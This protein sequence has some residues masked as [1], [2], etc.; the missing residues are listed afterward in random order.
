[1]KIEQFSRKI[2]RKIVRIIVHFPAKWY[3]NRQFKQAFTDDYDAFW[4]VDIDNTI[5]HTWP[6]MTPQYE[7]AFR[8]QS[9]KM[10]SFE[11]FEAMQQL[12]QDVPP[13]T[14][15]VFL[16]AR[17]YIRYFVT[18]RWLKKHGF[19]QTDSVIVL[20]E[21]MKDKAPLL[22]GVVKNYFDKKQAPQYL[23]NFEP[24]MG[25]KSSE[26][27]HYPIIY[28]DDL[29]YN[30]ENC[31]VLYYADVITAVQKIPIR[32][33]GYDELLEMQSAERNTTFKS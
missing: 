30:H 4:V 16:T 18:K 24:K 21:Y 26:S 33:I 1:M 20:V 25:I 17:Q 5:A 6:K 19:L 29:S 27:S 31:E 7:N 3:F 13:R 11:P 9:D 22:E 12:F 10:M 28:F 2:L 15:I 14:R 32:Y 23:G 8:S